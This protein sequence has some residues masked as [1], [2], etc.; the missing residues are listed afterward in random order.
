MAIA[1]S[2]SQR[3]SGTKRVKRP[4]FIQQARQL[5][6][7]LGTFFAPAI[8]FFA[9]TG[10]LQTFS[11]HERTRGSSYDPPVLLMKL[12]QLHKKQTLAIVQKKPAPQEA[13]NPAAHTENRAGAETA[14]PQSQPAGTLLMKWF[15]FVMAIGLVT[16]T[17]L[18]IYMS[19]KYNRDRRVVWGLL[20]AGTVLPTLIA[21]V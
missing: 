5:H 20:I 9:I 12:A 15:T 3:E 6:L 17:L 10:A 8:L 16:T 18:G 11:F 7:Y 2:A 4:N 14:K 13:G 1:Q 19:F 21:L